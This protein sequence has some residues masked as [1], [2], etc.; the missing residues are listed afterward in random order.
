VIEE[1][2]DTEKAVAYLEASALKIEGIEDIF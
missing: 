2:I 1:W